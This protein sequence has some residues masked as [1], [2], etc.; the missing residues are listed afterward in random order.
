MRILLAAAALALGGCTVTIT[1]TRAS[2]VRAAGL[3][4]AAGVL[5][6]AAPPEERA[7]PPMASER[8]IDER[9]CSRSLELSG[10][11]LRCR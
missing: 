11:N 3:V 4:L 10:G 2:H 5:L 8:S 6:S 9:D 1:D 7:A